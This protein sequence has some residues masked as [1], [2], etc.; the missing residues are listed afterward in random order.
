LSAFCRDDPAARDLSLNSHVCHANTM[1][2]N[3]A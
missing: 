2:H 3:S 1:P